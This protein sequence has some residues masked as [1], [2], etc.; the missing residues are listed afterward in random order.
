MYAYDRDWD[1]LDTC[2]PK[3]DKTL[4]DLMREETEKNEKKRQAKIKNLEIGALEHLMQGKPA[5][6]YLERYC[7]GTH[8]EDSRKLHNFLTDACNRKS[9][10]I[11]EIAAERLL[12]IYHEKSFGA[13]HA[14][15]ILLFT[16]VDG[17]YRGREELW[18]IYHDSGY[19]GLGKSARKILDNYETYLGESYSEGSGGFLGVFL[20]GIGLF[21]S[22]FANGWDAGYD[23]AGSNALFY[24]FLGAAAGLVLGGLAGKGLYK[25][26]HKYYAAREAKKHGD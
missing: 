21:Y 10:E 6:E 24:G 3:S 12:W 1:D 15:D 13:G 11:Y 26:Y 4:F 23:H 8:Y 18:K 9:D 25:L 16:K 22:A 2:Y 17:E 7:I 19:M 5:K 20:G 14:K